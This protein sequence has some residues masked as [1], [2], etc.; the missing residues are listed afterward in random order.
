MTL[1]GS[2]S[3]GRT[4]YVELVA[5]GKGDAFD[6]HVFACAVSVGAAEQERPLT[7]ALGLTPSNL[8]RLFN[9]YFPD[10]ASLIPPLPPSAGPGEDSIEE[11]DLRRLLLEHC[12][13]GTIEEQWLAAII[14][15]RSLRP[16]HLW[17]DLGLFNRSDLSRLLH[18]HF[19]ALAC[20][21]QGDMK[22]KK[23]FYRELCLREGVLICKSPVCD[24]C[25][26][27]AH[28]F[29]DEQGEPLARL[30]FPDMRT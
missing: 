7:E 26:D 12:R 22:W 21:N 16:N 1:L 14:A 25:S 17:Q 4:L 30:Q 3:G 23:F 6:R 2:P 28:C 9:A 5:H 19:E 24:V 10:G 20:R 29:G 11:P 13:R 8:T 15:R 18:R 27:Y